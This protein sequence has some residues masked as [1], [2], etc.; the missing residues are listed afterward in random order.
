L[1][2]SEGV[3]LIVCAISFQDSSLGLCDHK[4]PYTNVTDGQTD[5]HAIATALVTYEKIHCAVKIDKYL[6]SLVQTRK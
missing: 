1:A 5:G 3:G 2:K 4:S 6:Q